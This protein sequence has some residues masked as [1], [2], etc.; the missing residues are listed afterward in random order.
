[1][2]LKTQVSK[3]NQVLVWHFVAP[4][5]TAS[6]SKKK[7]KAAASSSSSSLQALSPI[8]RVA[9][10]KRAK[11][12]KGSDDVSLIGARFASASTLL[13]ASG[14]NVLPYFDVVVCLVISRVT[15]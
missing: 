8:F 9:L 14:S 12:A 11:G 13:V 15:V 1:L 10:A 3:S 7:D 6:S 5:S 4:A 2:V